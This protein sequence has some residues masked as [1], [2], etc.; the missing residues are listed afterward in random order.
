MSAQEQMTRAYDRFM[1][2][3]LVRRYYD[4]SGFF[5]FGYWTD[6]TKTQRAACEALVDQLV[7]RLPDK[8]GTILD[9]A[10]GLG[11][12]SK[13]LARTFPAELITGI[14]ISEAQIA[15]A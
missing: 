6:E 7:D 8:S 5:N 3:S 15:R 10:C 1:V 2:G 13:W 9:V 4:N 14:N 11:A 12:S